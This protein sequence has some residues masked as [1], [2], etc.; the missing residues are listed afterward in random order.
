MG[1]TSTLTLSRRIF[2]LTM[3]AIYNNSDYN[4]DTQVCK[5][6]VNDDFHNGIFNFIYNA[7]LCL[8]DLSDVRKNN[9][10]IMTFLSHLFWNVSYHY[11][12]NYLYIL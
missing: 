8:D 4:T 10:D 12:H 2:H 6:L 11:S 7:I 1:F 3:N 9:N 5:V